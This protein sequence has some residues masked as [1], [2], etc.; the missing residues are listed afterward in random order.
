MTF[1]LCCIL[2]NCTKVQCSV[3]L[4]CA[5][6][7]MRWCCVVVLCYCTALHCT[8]LHCIAPSC[9]VLFGLVVVVVVWLCVCYDVSC[10]YLNTLLFFKNIPFIPRIHSSPFFL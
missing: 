2:L 4:C 5:M 7:F 6:Y 10:I 1:L 8:A 3:H 9:A